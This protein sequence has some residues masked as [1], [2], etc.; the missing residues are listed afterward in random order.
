MHVPMPLSA[1]SRFPNTLDTD[2]TPIESALVAR[3]RAGDAAA[4]E[5]LFRRYYDRLYRFAYGFVS[6]RQDVAEEVVQHVFVRI[7]E[8]RSEWVVVGTVQS[9]LY[10]AVRNEAMALLRHERVVDAHAAAVRAAEA[11]SPEHVSRADEHLEHAEVQDALREAIAQLP[12][13]TREAFVLH[14]QHH[15][16]YAE[17]AAAM[18]ISIKGVEYHIGS[19]LRNLRKRL[20]DFV[21]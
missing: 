5:T 11:A 18:Q 8:R 2:A 17:I 15:L 3:V 7:W 4:F 16:T 12:E 13:R 14:R 9:Y 21:L 19:A 20:A 6:G 10:G 1:G